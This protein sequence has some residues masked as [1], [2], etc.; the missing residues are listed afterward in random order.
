MNQLKNSLYYFSVVMIFV[1]L[2]VA[3]ILFFSDGIISLQ[4]PKRIILAIVILLYAAFK[5]YRVLANKRTQQN[6][7]KN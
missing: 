6:D 7:E 2:A 3:M 4:G 5:A 1:Y